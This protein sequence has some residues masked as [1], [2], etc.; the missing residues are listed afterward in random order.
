MEDLVKQELVSFNQKMVEMNGLMLKELFTEFFERSSTI[1]L[2]VDRMG[3]IL[4]INDAMTNQL[5]WQKHEM[6]NR[7]L[8]EFVYHGDMS[9]ATNL[10]KAVMVHQKSVDGY[11]I[12]FRCKNGDYLPL[13]WNA[14]AS[15]SG[16]YGFGIARIVESNGFL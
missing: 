8:H 15:E 3:T 14:V 1:N 5:G 12:R 7:P 10:F 9:G 6:V 11:A 4:L 2:I 16:K 13:V